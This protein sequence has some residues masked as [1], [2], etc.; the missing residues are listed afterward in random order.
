M[1]LEF[2]SNLLIPVEIVLYDNKLECSSTNFTAR[3][4]RLTSI[5]MG[6]VRSGLQ[7]TRDFKIRNPNPMLLRF[8]ITLVKNSPA[9][10]FS[11]LLVDD[12]EQKLENSTL[13][14][15]LKPKNNITI[16]MTIRTSE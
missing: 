15:F 8:N 11:L 13:C 1:I 14:L 12:I 3:C 5:D 10:N 4:A 6:S 7:A 16:K 9:T 2:N